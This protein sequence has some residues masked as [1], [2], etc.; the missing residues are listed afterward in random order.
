MPAA[1]PLPPLAVAPAWLVLPALPRLP[2]LLAPGGELELLQ[3]S[4]ANANAHASVT[5]SE[6]LRIAPEYAGRSGNESASSHGGKLRFQCARRAA[7]CDSTDF[8]L[9]AFRKRL[10]RASLRAACDTK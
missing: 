4:D 6:M 2:P 5:P 3:C 9:P 1:A 7:V 8:I 10:A